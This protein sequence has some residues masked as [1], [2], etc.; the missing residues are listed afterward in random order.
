MGVSSLSGLLDQ[1]VE[2]TDGDEVTLG[3][4]L[5][6]LD[7]RSYGPML[8]GPAFIALSPI[9]GIP[10]MSVITGTIIIVIA[11][12]M[13]FTPHPWLPRRLLCITISRERLSNGVK[14][15]QPWVKWFERGIR[16]R[17]VFLTKSPADY[18]IAAISILLA[19]LFYPLALVPAGVAVPSAAIVMLSLALT[20]RDGL[21]AAAGFATSAASLAVVYFF[22]PF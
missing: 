19:L 7:S 1:F 22:W 16:E 11:V 5:D 12:Q 20:A 21:L 6:A 4:L 8:L 17:Y 14:K 2:N 3:D 15:A 10:G 9:G 18:V 13:F